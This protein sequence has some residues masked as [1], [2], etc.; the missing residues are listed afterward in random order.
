MVGGPRA[1]L[2]TAIAT[3][4]TVAC[5]SHGN[6]VGPSADAGDAAASDPVWFSEIGVAAGLSHVRTEAE[7]GTLQ[8]RMSG[9]VCVFDAD[10]DGALDLFFPGSSAVGSGSHLY[11]ARGGALVFADE[12]KAR[13]IG[14]T[15]D[16]AGCL[17]FDVEGDGDVDV[18]TTGYGGAHLFVNDGHGAFADA[19]ARLGTPFDP[20]DVTTSAVAFDADSDGDLDLAIGIYGR[21]KGPPA[22]GKCNSPCVSDIQR[23]DYGP[24]KLL[25]QRDD[26]GFDD[27]T[28]RLGSGYQEPNLVLLATDLDEDGLVDLFVGNDITSFPDRY[29]RGDGKGGFKE[30]GVALGVSQNAN[31]SGIYSM[32]AFEADVDGDGHLDLLESSNDDEINAFFRCSAG[33]C[34]D[35]AAGLGF[36][37][38]PHNFRWGQALVDFD[39]DGV[40]EMFEA[41]SH[42]QI[43]SDSPDG[44]AHF[45]TMDSCLIWHRTAVDVPF[46]KQAAVQDRSART[47]GRGLVTVDLDHDGALDVVVGT[48]LGRPL[49]FHNVRAGRGQSLEVRL[50]G[51][52]KNTHGVGARITARAGSRTWSSIV[53]AGL[54]FMSSEPG[55]VHI[56]LGASAQLDSLDVRWPSG[57]ASHLT[58]VPAGAPLTVTEP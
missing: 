30:V 8:G 16:S 21:F 39:D 43:D 9:G 19:T 40:V 23:Y 11:M 42:Y 49:L 58:N 41:V 5:G 50:R 2:L 18:L 31:G 32:S 47:G 51:A 44:A 15:G 25:A 27:A 14:D 20:H 37:E 57:K 34:T 26:G 52:G 13:G 33:K 6:A 12:A 17:A 38:T 36:G 48:I 28:A 56:G 4:A 7:Y 55:Y 54:S 53:H 1:W 46:V 10:S 45:L 22:T 29:Y 35:V 24:T 3:S